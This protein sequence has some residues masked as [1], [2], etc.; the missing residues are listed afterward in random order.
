MGIRA[1]VLGRIY[2]CLKGL[3]EVLSKKSYIIIPIL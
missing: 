2:R 3:G 1:E